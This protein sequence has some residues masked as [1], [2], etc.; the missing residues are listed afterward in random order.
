[1]NFLIKHK[2]IKTTDIFTSWDSRAEPVA[3]ANELGIEKEDVQSYLKEN[4][5]ILKRKNSED[6]WQLDRNYYDD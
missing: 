1:M 5:D 2:K 4:L 3:I 6:L